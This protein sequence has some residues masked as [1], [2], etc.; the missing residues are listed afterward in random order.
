M[1]VFKVKVLCD[2]V[3]VEVD[4]V[5]FVLGDIIIIKFGDIIFVDVRFF[6]GDFLFVD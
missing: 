4:V 2:G 3:Y 1:L 6:D 5:I